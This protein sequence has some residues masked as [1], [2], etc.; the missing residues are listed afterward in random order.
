MLD[1]R[2]P[3]TPHSTLRTS[4]AT[5]SDPALAFDDLGRRLRVAL[6]SL[7]RPAEAGLVSISIPSS[8]IDLG[9]FLPGDLPGFY[10]SR[11]SSGVTLLGYGVATRVACSGDGRMEEASRAFSDLRSRWLRLG[12]PDAPT[13]IAFLGFAFSPEETPGGEWHGLANTELVVPELL[14]RRRG[15]EAWITAT[16]MIGEDTDPDALAARWIGRLEALAEAQ[17]PDAVPG[18]APVELKRVEDGSWN[19]PLDKALADIRAGRLDKVVL[20]RRVRYSTS[21]PLS[22]GRVLAALEEGHESCA[23][24]AVVRPGFALVGVSPERLVS[25]DHGVVAADALAGTAPRGATAALDRTLA[26]RLRLDPKA[27]VE[28]Q[29]V[30]D[31][32]REA[33]QPCCSAL[34]APQ[35]PEIMSLPTVHHLWSP[36]GGHLRNGSDLLE[37]ARRLHPTPAVGGS[38]RTAALEWLRR[39]E[40]QSRGWYTGALGWLDSDGNGEMSVVLRCGIVN[41]G[42]VD[43]FAGAGIVADSRPDQEL[44]ETEWKL[45]TLRGALELG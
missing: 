43:L 38:P 10:W 2:R 19:A 24:F 27:L 14:C 8:V 30:V 42:S 31:Q 20:T 45:C 41:Q 4:Q 7:T 40:K 29:I 13:P 28:H 11:S 17:A 5:A 9:P 21:R 39:H 3:G 6:S 26:D 36:V 15:D 35:G 25:L 37:L 18:G 33:L 12:D 32:I 22:W 44:A 23:R 34:L 1:Y 16:A